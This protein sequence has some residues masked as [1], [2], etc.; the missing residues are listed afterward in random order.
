MV[1]D[2]QV[3]NPLGLQ[4]QYALTV[5]AICRSLLFSSGLH[6]VETLEWLIWPLPELHCCNSKSVPWVIVSSEGSCSL[7][8]TV[9][10]MTVGR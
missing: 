4:A 5:C 3:Q 2:S 1:L 10:P 9:S 8:P 7:H 6:V